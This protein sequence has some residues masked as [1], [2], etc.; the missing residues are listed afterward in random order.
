MKGDVKDNFLPPGTGSTFLWSATSSHSS[1]SQPRQSCGTIRNIACTLR[2]AI[3]SRKK[4]RGFNVP[5]RL[6]NHSVDLVDH[7]PI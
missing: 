3:Q 1:V 4:Q 5:S 6:L 2:W 7:G